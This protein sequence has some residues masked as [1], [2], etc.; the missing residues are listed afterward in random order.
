MKDNDAYGLVA[1]LVCV[2]LQGEIAASFIQTENKIN[3][4]YLR[5]L[6][7]LMKELRERDLI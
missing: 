4:K 7:A 2:D 6:N 1:E 3:R 5:M